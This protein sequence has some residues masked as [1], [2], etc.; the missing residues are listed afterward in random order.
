MKFEEQFPSLKNNY[1]THE[2]D[3]DTYFFKGDIE[4]L[5]LDKQK[6]REAIR[7]V[8]N[9]ARFREDISGCIRFSSDLKKELGL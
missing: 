6:V 8:E 9:Y 3:G 4:V 7:R 5:C 2:I 1:N